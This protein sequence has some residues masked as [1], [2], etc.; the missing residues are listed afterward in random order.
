MQPNYCRKKDKTDNFCQS[1]SIQ[2]LQALGAALFI[3]LFSSRYCFT[4]VQMQ[5]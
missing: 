2:K 4:A 5:L 1:T 3:C